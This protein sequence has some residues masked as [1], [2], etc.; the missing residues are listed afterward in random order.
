MKPE[1]FAS[2]QE[3]FESM[4]ANL[5]IALAFAGLCV[6]EAGELKT[7]ERSTTLSEAKRRAQELRADLNR[8]GVH[9]DV[10]RFCREELLAEN[11]FHA[12]FEAVK[13]VAQKIRTMTD[14]T[15]DGAELINRALTGN[16]PMLAIN[17]L[18]H[19]SEVSEQ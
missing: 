18:S 4:R 10:V 14:L 17:S 15:D 13:S 6:N 11:Y 8:R 5:N 12:V 2:C 7:A 9:P 3:R 19:E 16:P 1:R